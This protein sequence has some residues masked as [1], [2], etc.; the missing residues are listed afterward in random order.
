MRLSLADPF[1]MRAPQRWLLFGAAV[2]L[3]AVA[4]K[5][6]DVEPSDL[7]YNGLLRLFGNPSTQIPGLAAGASLGFLLGV[8]HLT[9]I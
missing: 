5:F 6:M 1:A 2:V 3:G 8:I 7:A 4:G 9:S